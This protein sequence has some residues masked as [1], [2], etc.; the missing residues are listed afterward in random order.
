MRIR[1]RGACGGVAA[2]VLLASV[3]PACSGAVDD[4]GDQTTASPEVAEEEPEAATDEDTDTPE[5]TEEP[6]DAADPTDEATEVAEPTD[7]QPTDEQAGD[8]VIEDGRHPTFLVALDETDP[9]VT[10]D[11]IQF[12]TG[13]QAAV[14]Y[15]EDV[16]DDPDPGPPNDYW[17]RNESSELRTLPISPEVTVTV[18]RLG[19]SSGADPAP[20]TLEELPAHLA[21]QAGAPAGQLGWSPFW[22][23]VEDGVVVAI[24]EQYLP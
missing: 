22:L 6:M 24:D 18:I 2:L 21:A 19:E 20:W 5:P 9:T 23:T 13:E 10:F 15:A 7:E 11:L 16:P 8:A 3:A 1:G 17:I 4:A 12:L 14:A